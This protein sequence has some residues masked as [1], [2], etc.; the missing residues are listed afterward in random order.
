MLMPWVVTY[1][2][3]P[4]SDDGQN[5]H[6]AASTS[7]ARALMLAALVAVVMVSTPGSGDGRVVARPPCRRS[8]DGLL[9]HREGD[10]VERGD[11][12]VGDRAGDGRD[13]AREGADGAA[14]GGADGGTAVLQ[15]Q[16]GGEAL[17]HGVVHVLV[18]LEH[19]RVDEGLVR[20]VQHV[21]DVGGRR[22]RDARGA[23]T[24]DAGL[25]RVAGREGRGGDRGT[26]DRDTGEQNARLAH[27]M[28][29]FSQW[30]RAA[31]MLLTR[32]SDSCAVFLDTG[33]SA[34]TAR[35]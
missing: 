24:G 9:G 27:C 34:A 2:V 3:P 22:A 1:V 4:P 5:N 14:H 32:W 19:D 23:V 17:G 21:V 10:A 31:R 35:T 28:V 26:G 11:R 13:A 29:L 18:Q 16:P 20:A 8:A 15:L 25:D 6:T 33:F 7:A 12:R 30:L